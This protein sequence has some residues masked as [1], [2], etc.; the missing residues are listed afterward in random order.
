MCHGYSPSDQLATI[1]HTLILQ[2]T[3]FQHRSVK[4]EV[5]FNAFIA[6]NASSQSLIH[7]SWVGP[8]TSALLWRSSGAIRSSAPTINDIDLSRMYANLVA[9]VRDSHR[10]QKYLRCTYTTWSSTGSFCCYWCVIEYEWSD[11]ESALFK[12][13]IELFVFSYATCWSANLIELER[14]SAGWLAKSSRI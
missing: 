9:S 1:K 10:G 8:F 5:S 3:Y 14:R 7:P 6:G 4:P 12:F 11:W 2:P 13:P